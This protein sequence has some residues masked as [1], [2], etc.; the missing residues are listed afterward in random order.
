MRK[1]MFIL[2][3]LL[4]NGLSAWAEELILTTYYPAPNGRYLNMSVTGTFTVQ[5]I[6]L[7]GNLTTPGTIQGETLIAS[8]TNP[9]ISLIRLGTTL[10]S[11]N[12]G[13]SVTASAVTVNNGA[14][15]NQSS[16][17]GVHFRSERPSISDGALSCWS[18]GANQIGC[19]GLSPTRDGLQIYTNIQPS[20][21]TPN[22][23]FTGGNVA[24]MGGERWY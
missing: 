13:G 15:I 17:T 20:G 16:S 6:T 12:S 24:F 8:G 19:V 1:F 7:L 4:M 2:A 9:S 3:A 5:T 11:V 21:V 10:F 14:F 18:T 22:I 23:R